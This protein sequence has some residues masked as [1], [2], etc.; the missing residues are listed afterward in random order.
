MRFRHE[1]LFRGCKL[2]GRCFGGSKWPPVADFLAP[3]QVGAER[4]GARSVTAYLRLKQRRVEVVLDVIMRE[5][6]T[7]AKGAHATRVRERAHDVF[8]SDLPIL[9]GRPTSVYG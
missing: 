5:L 4:D 1:S 8:V 3:V 7:V 2:W 6:A 9:E